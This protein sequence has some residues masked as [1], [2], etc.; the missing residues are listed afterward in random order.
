MLCLGGQNSVE[1]TVTLELLLS[2]ACTASRPSLFLT[3]P[4]SEKAGGGKRLGGDKARTADPSGPKGYSTPYD[5]MVSS[6]TG[7]GVCVLCSETGLASISCC[8]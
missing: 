1:N 8:E 3:W 2:S 4:H 7:E 5:V 6:K